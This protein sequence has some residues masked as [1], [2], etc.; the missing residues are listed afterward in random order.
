MSQVLN[1]LM[2]RGIIQLQER[3]E[4]MVEQLTSYKQAT[5][6]VVLLVKRSDLAFDAFIDA[7]RTTEQH[8]LANTLDKGVLQQ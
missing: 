8:A 1:M 3:E 7:L 5:G 2:G 6:L 4:L